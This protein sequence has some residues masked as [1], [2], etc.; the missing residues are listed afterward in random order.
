VKTMR[1]AAVLLLLF[2][3]FAT[4]FYFLQTEKAQ[5]SLARRILTGIPAKKHY[6]Q[7]FHYA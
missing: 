4:T 1:I 2:I 7:S 5:S 3:P 6:R